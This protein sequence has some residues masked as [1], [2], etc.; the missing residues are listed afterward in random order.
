[1]MQAC[2]LM[3][4][5]EGNKDEELDEGVRNMRWVRI[6]EDRAFGN[7]ASIPLYWNRNTTMFNE[8]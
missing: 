7:A 5:L 6:L 2:N 3:L 4:G 1:M 8:A